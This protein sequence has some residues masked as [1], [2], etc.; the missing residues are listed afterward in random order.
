MPDGHLLDHLAVVNLPA[1]QEAEIPALNGTGTAR[2]IARLFAVLAEGG[3]LDNIRLVSQSSIRRF[4]TVQ[5]YAP[6]AL[7]L[8][9]D[10]PGNAVE[11]HMRMLG[12][13][14]SSK[15]FGLP[16]RLGPSRTAFGHDGAGGQV[17][18]ADPEAGIAAGFVRSSVH[19]EDRVFGQA[20][21]TAVCVRRPGVIRRHIS[22]IA[23]LP[24]KA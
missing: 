20:A 21:R 9:A 15:P 22:P 3:E 23:T 8:E 7:E 19:V 16:R 24:G 14:G 5:I 2:S 11:L 10:P 13:H 12:Y 18:F 6:N 17:G 4:R 1:F